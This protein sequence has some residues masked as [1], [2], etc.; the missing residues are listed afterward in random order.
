MHVEEIKTRREGDDVLGT[1]GRPGGDGATC[2]ARTVA[3]LVFSEWLSFLLSLFLCTRGRQ[4]HVK[5]ASCARL[6]SGEASPEAVFFQRAEDE[7]NTSCRAKQILTHT[8]TSA[9]SAWL[10]PALATLW[11]CK[12]CWKDAF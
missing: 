4:R 8:H 12:M 1:L 11:Y 5:E 2:L 7:S 10:C 9:P 6:L 3:V